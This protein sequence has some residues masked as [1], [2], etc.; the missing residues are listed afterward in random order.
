MDKLIQTAKY[1]IIYGDFKRENSVYPYQ[2][3][4]RCPRELDNSDLPRYVNENR[5]LLGFEADT[6]TE[7][8]RESDRY[9][10]YFR[11]YFRN[12]TWQGKWMEANGEIKAIVCHGIDEI[13]KW[14]SGNFPHHCNR[15]NYFG[16]YLDNF[17]WCMRKSLC[18]L[19]KYSIY[20]PY[21]YN[22]IC[23]DNTTRLNL[24]IFS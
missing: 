18:R 2:E 7:D 19:I 1:S 14:L 16:Y 11:M 20:I 17:R 24:C 22:S 4:F 3:L 9:F 12:G 5:C 23:Y 10:G 13:I 15:I 8:L 21:S 6:E